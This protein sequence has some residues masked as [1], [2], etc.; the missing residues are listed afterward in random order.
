L[1]H[2]VA[3]FYF[4]FFLGSSFFISI[5]DDDDDDALYPSFSLSAI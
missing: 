2:G 1:T 4:G 5:E 3:T